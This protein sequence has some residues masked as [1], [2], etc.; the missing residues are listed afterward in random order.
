VDWCA[1]TA[2][3]ARWPGGWTDGSKAIQSYNTL[4]KQFPSNIT[5]SVFGFAGDYPHFE[6]PQE[7]TAPPKVDFQR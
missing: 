5:A 6:V 1:P 7:A 3:R 2:H 4:R